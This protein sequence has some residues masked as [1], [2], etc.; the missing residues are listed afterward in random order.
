MIFFLFVSG[1]KNVLLVIVYLMLTVLPTTHSAPST[2]NPP[3]K[4]TT[5]K[6]LRNCLTEVNIA[7]A[8]AENDK[9]N[10]VSKLIFIYH[11][12]FCQW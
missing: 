11:I 5:A 1:L 12:I 2:M 9:I 10:F 6:W 3:R 4:A 7:K 8:Y